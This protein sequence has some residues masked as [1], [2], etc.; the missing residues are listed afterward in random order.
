VSL[1]RYEPG[2]SRIQVEAELADD[3][4]DPLRS[5]NN[6][7]LQNKLNTIFEQLNNWFKSNLLFFEFGK[8]LLYSIH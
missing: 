7:Q 6:I 2:S 3:T 5:P 4:S 1:P 8:N